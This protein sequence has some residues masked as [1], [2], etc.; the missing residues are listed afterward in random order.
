MEL[1]SELIEYAALL[2]EALAV[3]IMLVVIAVATVRWLAQSRIELHASYQ[4][5]RVLLGRALLIGLELLVAADIIR[6]VVVDNSL[7]SVLALGGLVLVRTFLSW[8]VSVELEGRWPWQRSRSG[9]VESA[10]RSE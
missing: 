9:D 7:P 8:S 4:R 10:G 5:Y 2:V 6:T 3:M 1:V